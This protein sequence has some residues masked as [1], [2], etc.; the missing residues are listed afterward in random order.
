MI[1]IWKKNTVKSELLNLGLKNKTR[2]K[3]GLNAKKKLFSPWAI[4]EISLLTTDLIGISIIVHGLKEKLA[5]SPIISLLSHG[6]F[7]KLREISDIV[8]GLNIGY[9]KMPLLNRFKSS[10]FV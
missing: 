10:F 2:F 1:Y 3:P 7:R 9:E 6:L 4:S 5:I 8:H